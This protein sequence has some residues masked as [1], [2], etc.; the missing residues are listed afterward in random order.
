VLARD[1]SLRRHG[2]VLLVALLGVLL[3]TAVRDV[4]DPGRDVDAAV[5][6]ALDGAA[7]AVT[8]GRIELTTTP[9]R[10]VD[11]V[12]AALVGAHGTT[13]ML[14]AAGSQGCYALVVTDLGTLIGRH[15]SDRWRCEPSSGLAMAMNRGGEVGPTVTVEDPYPWDLPGD[16][17]WRSWYLLTTMLLA[18]VAVGVSARIAIV[19]VTGRPFGEDLDLY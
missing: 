15:F 1:A 14:V 17:P 18:M 5:V 11:G 3:A 7:R 19:L 6:A 2:V 10:V 12:S 8:A 4:P 16:P 13:P 9:R